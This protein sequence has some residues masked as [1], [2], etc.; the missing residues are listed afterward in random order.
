VKPLRLL[1]RINKRRSNR[2][3]VLRSYPVEPYEAACS[4]R[5]QLRAQN[6]SIR[7]ASQFRYF[8]PFT[9]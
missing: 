3:P 2:L 7:P 1:C 8:S 4:P 6:S 5:E 9:H